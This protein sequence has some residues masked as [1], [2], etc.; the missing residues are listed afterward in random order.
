MAETI[1]ERATCENCGADVRENTQFCY[2]CGK[3]FTEAD[4]VANGDEPAAM[5]DDAQTALDDLAAKLKM[6]DVVD[7]GDRIA[8]AAAE[9]KRS[10]IAPKRPKQA[11]WEENDSGPSWFFFVASLLI[12]MIVAAVVFITLYWK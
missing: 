2:N 3:S 5:S 4:I 9:R 7:S 8:L 1:V 6:E 11:V 12:F 10:R